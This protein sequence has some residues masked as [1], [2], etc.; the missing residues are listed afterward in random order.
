M[1]LICSKGATLSADPLWSLKK[2]LPQ[3]KT[4]K[5]FP[6]NPTR[7][8]LAPLRWFALALLALPLAAQAVNISGTVTNG[9]T[10]KPD[11]G[12]SVYLIS[13]AN[14]MQQVG[15]TKTNAA[16][17]YT[18]ALPDSN[19]HL[20]RVDH[21]TASYYAPVPPGATHTD[22]TVYDVAAKVAGVV[23]ED[24]VFQMQTDSDGLHVIESFFVQNNSKPARTQ[25][26]P[27]AYVIHLPPGAQI[28]G[29][30]AA[31]A[32]NMPISSMP[33]PIDSKGDY[34]FVFPIRPGTTRFAV[35]YSL[36]YAG[37][38]TFHL[39]E[40][41]P[42]ANVAVMLP[43]SMTF[44]THPEGVFA[45]IHDQSVPAQTYVAKNVSAAENISFT[46]T[47]TGSLPRSQQDQATSQSSAAA[48]TAQND[49]PGMGLGRPI[50]TPGPLHKYRWWIL[51]SIGL[52]LVVIAAFMLRTQP[53][54]PGAVP[55]QPEPSP[56]EPTP[57]TVDVS[58]SAAGGDF[59]QPWRGTSAA[60]TPAAGSAAT[61][62][63]P[64]GSVDLLQSLKEELFT[65]ETE[66]VE[67]KLTEEQYT[68]TKA[69]LEVVLRRALGR[70]S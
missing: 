16:G 47:G 65:L 17:H 2:N 63:N 28:D 43:N 11:A 8:A 15:S 31:D 18:M 41:T 60:G 13:L 38:F 4:R 55:V 46:V 7:S 1:R 70:R 61:S 35:S 24:D 23:T 12:D 57:R 58:A 6:V 62:A 51:S 9:T 25:Y 67:G 69:A 40:P 3:T 68:L 54:A 39:A 52:I 10:G 20:I 14:G 37:K 44:A 42:A 49:R 45:P 34:A 66:R 53:A 30:Q 29:G 27:H 64:A 21:Q 59:Q 33:A 5:R 22:V 56:L 50:D 32:S 36:P 19:M 26:G 48:Q